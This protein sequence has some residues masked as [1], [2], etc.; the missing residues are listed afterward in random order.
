MSKKNDFERYL[1]NR[2]VPVHDCKENGGRVSSLAKYGTWL[3]RNHNQ[4]FSTG[5]NDWAGR[6]Q[7]MYAV[8]FV[9]IRMVREGSLPYV[10]NQFDA[11]KVVKPLFNGACHEMCIVMGLDIQSNPTCVSIVTTGLVNECICDMAAVFKPLLLSNSSSFIFFHNHPANSL[12]PSRQDLNL[13][14]NLESAG[15]IMNINMVDNIIVDSMVDNSYS[16]KNSSM[17]KI[18]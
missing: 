7:K 15:K 5:F 16:I 17:R 9:Q 4:E 14:R 2:G 3:R 10:G 11:V 8:P 1:N 12:E 6:G 18:S 13:S